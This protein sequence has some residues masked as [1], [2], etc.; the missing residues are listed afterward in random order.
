MRKANG[1]KVPLQNDCESEEKLL[2]TDESVQRLVDGYGS[3]FDDEARLES[4]RMT[5]RLY[6]Y[7]SLFSPIKINR[8]LLYTS[9]CV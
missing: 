9:R 8:C 6:P 1:G 2:K 4:G 7:E 5:K 3:W